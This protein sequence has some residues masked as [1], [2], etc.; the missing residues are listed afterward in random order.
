MKKLLFTVSFAII[1]ISNMA[2]QGISEAGLL[3]AGLQGT[4]LN[5]GISAKYNLTEIHTAQLVIGGANYGFGTSALTLT[6]RYLYNFYESG[7]VRPYAGGQLGY[8]S[9]KFDLGQ[10]G[11]D[12][13]TAL[14]YGVFG[15]VEY[16]FN[17]LD[18]LGF[19]AEIG[20]GGGSFGSGLPSF[21]G[22]TVGAGIHYYFN[23]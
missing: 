13:Y 17:G 4:S 10:F 5:Y 9:V 1:V 2:A 8:W 21:T 11:K 22:I 6:G 20:Y 15:G 16:A 19:S 12:K 14:A 7:N 18:Q 23:L 3:G